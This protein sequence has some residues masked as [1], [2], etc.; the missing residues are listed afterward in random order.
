MLE[1]NITVTLILSLFTIAHGYKFTRLIKKSQL[2]NNQV[3]LI[4]KFRKY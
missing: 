4:K 3:A 2:K 1:G